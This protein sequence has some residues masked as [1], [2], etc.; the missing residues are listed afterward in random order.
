[1]Y[2]AA[3]GLPQELDIPTDSLHRFYVDFAALP[4]GYYEEI[5]VSDLL[6]GD[7]PAELFQDAIVLIGPYAAG[8]VRLCHHRHRPG[9]PDVWRGVPGQRHRA[10]A[11]GRVQ[12]GGFRRDQA[13]LLF[14]ISAV[15]L[16]LFIDR[17]MLVATLLWLAVAGGGLLLCLWLYTVGYVLHPLWLTLTGNGVLR[18]RRGGQLCAC[19]HG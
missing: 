4:G 13:A 5:S 18:R 9:F 1:M 7:F 14:V 10:N 16:Y 6:S 12:G 8:V 11:S 19:R 17:K 3:M 2:A 15:C